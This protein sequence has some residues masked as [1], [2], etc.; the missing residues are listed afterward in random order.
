MTNRITLTVFLLLGCAW[1]VTVNAEA[2][3]GETYQEC[4]RRYGN[5]VA[6][7]ANGHLFRHHAMHVFIQFHKDRAWHALYFK[8]QDNI[9]T[10]LRQR[11][12]EYSAMTERTEALRNIPFSVL[13][14]DGHASEEP[15]RLMA[16]TEDEV[17]AILNLYGLDRKKYR[18]AFEDTYTSSDNNLEAQATRIESLLDARVREPT[19]RHVIVTDPSVP[20]RIEAEHREQRRR[21]LEGL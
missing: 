19:Y 21:Q 18:L 5:P 10:Y 6:T 11:R 7:M 12:E 3:V 9:Q 16:M 2:R 1:F 4:V 20:G 13:D 15:F 8:Y 17:T 14:V